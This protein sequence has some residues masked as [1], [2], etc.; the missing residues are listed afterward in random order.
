L[1]IF[2]SGTQPTPTDDSTPRLWDLTS[3]ALSCLRSCS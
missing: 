1:V 2:Y 3:V